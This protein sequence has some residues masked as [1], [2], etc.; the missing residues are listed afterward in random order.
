MRVAHLGLPAVVVEE[1]STLRATASFL[2]TA[3]L[4]APVRAAELPPPIEARRGKSWVRAACRAALLSLRM[5][6]PITDAVPECD[7]AG[8]DGCRECLG[9]D[10]GLRASGNV[11]SEIAGGDE[12][13]SR[14]C[15]RSAA[16]SSCKK[17][18]SNDFCEMSSQPSREAHATAFWYFSKI[19]AM[20]AT[21]HRAK[22]IA[23]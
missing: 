17:C 22:C 1:S 19:L 12:N 10:E 9:G 13:T 4:T 3:P 2:S 5:R 14:S 21:L 7:R 11:D 18:C 16:P 6:P 15:V 8:D 23:E 20:M